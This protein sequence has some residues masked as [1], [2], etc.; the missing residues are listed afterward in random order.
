MPTIKLKT[1][2]NVP[3]E[4][5]FDL[6]RCITLHEKSMSKHKEKAI[7][8]I[9][10]GLINLGESVTWEATHFGI[11]QKL[12]SKITEF[13]RPNHFQDTMTKGA[14]KSF[15]HDHFFEQSGTKT[16]MRD[17]FNYTSPMRILGKIA[18]LIFLEKY[19]TELLE[20][21]NELIRKVAESGDWKNFIG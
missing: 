11:K 10:E 20:E 18:D 4:R 1:T 5:V 19:M 14:F 3:I 16:I 12:T 17:V 8:G 6:S 21:R 7:G 13:D 2:I 15:I 9:T